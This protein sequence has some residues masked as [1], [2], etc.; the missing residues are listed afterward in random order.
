M[1]SRKK[2]AMIFSDMIDHA[3]FSDSYEYNENPLKL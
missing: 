3:V 2:N 1:Y